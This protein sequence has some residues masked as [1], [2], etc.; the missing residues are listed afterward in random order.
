MDQIG[1][2]CL[3]VMVLGLAGCTKAADAP[4][5]VDGRDAA[6]AVPATSPAPSA[7]G[8]PRGAMT[9]GTWTGRYAAAPGPFSVPDGGE[10]SGVKFR[11]EDAS[12]G[13]G[14]GVLS[15]TLDSTGHVTGALEGPLGPL[16][17]TGELADGAFSASLV[18]STPASG[19]AGVAVGTAAGD[20]IAGTMHL[21]LPT[22]NVLR[23]ASFTLDRKR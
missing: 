19:F 21:S 8:L 2:V 12:V 5:G 6:L 10:W 11:G 14:E 16:G 23:E 17:I 7:S 15:I 18:S 9:G 1:S 22:G 3:A 20:R 4:S 13:L